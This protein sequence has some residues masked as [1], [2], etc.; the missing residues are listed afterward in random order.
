MGVRITSCDLLASGYVEDQKMRLGRLVATVAL[1]LIAG[2]AFA[3]VK[4]EQ[5]PAATIDGGFSWYAQQDDC[6]ALYDVELADDFLCGDG[7]P[8]TAVEWW[9]GHDAADHYLIRFYSDIPDPDPPNPLTWSQPGDLL[10]EEGCWE[11]TAVYDEGLNQYRFS[12]YLAVPFCQEFGV[13]YWFSVTG[14]VCTPAE[15]AT[16]CDCGTVPQWNDQ[17]VIRSETWPGMPSE[18]TAMSEYA[19]AYGHREL[20]FVLHGPGSNVVCVPDPQV[21]SLAD[22]AGGGDYE[23][24]V[25]VDYLGGGSGDLWGY[26]IDVEWDNTVVSAVLA[27]FSRPDNGPFNAG[28]GFGV[29]ELDSDTNGLKKVRIDA[30]LGGITPGTSGPC[31]LFKAVFTA[32]DTPDYATSVVGLTIQEVRDSD[33]Q[34]LTGFFA[35]NGEVIVDLVG[36][37]ITGVSIENDTVYPTTGS[38]AWVK[39]TDDLTVY[40]TVTDG[41]GLASVTADATDFGG[42]GSLTPDLGTTYEWT[43]LGVDTGGATALVDVTVTATD[44][45]GNTS[46]GSDDITAD[47]TLPGTVAG[48]SAAPAHQEVVLSWDDASGAPADYYGVMVRY[49]IWNDYP[50]Y[51]LPDPAPYPT[52]EDDGLEAFSGDAPTGTTH[53]I[54]P[55]DIHYYS[56]F[57]YDWALN[58][59]TVVTAGQDR[60]TN[61]W[62][63]DVANTADSWMPD[64]LVTVHDINKLAGTYGVSPVGYNN[65]ECDVGP[66]DD[67]SRVGIPTPDGMIQFEDLMIFSMNYG[68]VAAKVVPFLGKPGVGDLALALAE[69]GRTDGGVLELALRLEGN[70]GDVKGFTAELEFEG[71]EFLSARLSDDM[72]SPV[73]DMFFWSNATSQSVQVDAAVLGTDVTIGGSGD[74]VLFTFQVLDGTYAVD[75][76]STQLRGAANEDLTAELEGLSSEGVPVAFKLVQNS[77]NPFNP[78]TKVAY[79]VPSASRVTI[80]VFD[81]TGRLVT[82]LVDGV[83]EPG[84]HAAVWNGTNENGESVGSG[85]YF[86]TMETPDYRDSQKMTLLK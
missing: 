81:V 27:D 43:L 80:R 85:V 31:E 50:L 79:H 48:L 36:P 54:V 77:P 2:A 46:T 10:Y 38:H 69:N 57:V 84:R 4:W 13:I 23:D 74:V 24:E 68:V 28:V 39:D 83:V 52:D 44:S 63:G 20:A 25:V 6:G 16:W 71:L 21:I 12:Q 34:D 58:Y 59:G 73:A 1:V 26:S 67:H 53:G 41:G 40:A 5:Y 60:A 76:T 30:A 45:Y 56:A 82:T 66:T 33:N 65:S 15:W 42:G 7:F 75:F 8:I 55:R 72:S 19:S 18:W 37:A 35:D 3:E 29:T 64:G 70:A 62:L 49:D 9:G 22:D 14:V 32:F 11:F 47:N 17:A 61:Y 86:C 78:V 51:G